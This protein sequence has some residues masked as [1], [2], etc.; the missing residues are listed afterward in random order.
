MIESLATD[1][2]VQRSTIT[3]L[4]RWVMGIRERLE[5]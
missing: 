1:P 4:D 3:D 2:E 5:S